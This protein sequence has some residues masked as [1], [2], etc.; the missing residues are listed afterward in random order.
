MF[1]QDWGS[2]TKLN[3]QTRAWGRGQFNTHAAERSYTF[4]P[5]FPGLLCL[6]LQARP[7]VKPRGKSWGSWALCTV[8][9][10]LP[11]RAWCPLRFSFQSAL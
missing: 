8:W 5:P 3:I 2:W 11:H 4:H 7:E 6:L 9:L 10:C 1:L